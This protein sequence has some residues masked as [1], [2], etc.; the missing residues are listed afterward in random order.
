MPTK[1]Y[2]DLVHIDMTGYVFFLCTPY[3]YPTQNVEAYHTPWVV[4]KDSRDSNY[5][6]AIRN[7]KH[8]HLMLIPKRVD[9][10][11]CISISPAIDQATGGNHVINVDEWLSINGLK[12]P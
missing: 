10:L 8:P 2:I 9:V 3:F 7:V 11:S 6:T 4:V 5:G 1:R 12:R